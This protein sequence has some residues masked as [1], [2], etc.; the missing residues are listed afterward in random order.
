MRGTARAESFSS[1]G[2]PIV[3]DTIFHRLTPRAATPTVAQ[4]FERKAPSVKA[5]YSALL[6]AVEKL[7]PFQEDPKKRAYA[8]G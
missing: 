6:Q 7:G 3:T 1:P 8:S 4:H 5:T 2:A